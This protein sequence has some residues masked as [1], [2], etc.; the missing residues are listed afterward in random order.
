MH[1]MLGYVDR[2]SVKP[3]GKITLMASSAGGAAFQTRIA[4]IQCGDP[5]PR[6][7]GYREIGMP[8]ATDGTHPG[9][10]QWTHLGSW[11]RIPLLNLGGCDGA[12]VAVA[13]IWPTTP[14]KGTQG[15][16]AWVGEDGVRLLLAL[17]PEGVV[18]SLTTPAGNNP[19][20]HR[21]AAFGAS[22]VRHLARGQFE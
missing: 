5:N 11:G 16:L 3:G 19:S 22:L 18:A 12:L 2:W 13:T 7:P 20:Q 8:H 4:R 21:Q 9:R 14:A 10:E 1:P 15:I 6:G 17:S